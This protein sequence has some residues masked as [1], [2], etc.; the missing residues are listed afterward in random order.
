MSLAWDGM[1]ALNPPPLNAVHAKEQSKLPGLPVAI[2]TSFHPPIGAVDAAGA[3]RRRAPPLCA[4]SVRQRK[5]ESR[6]ACGVSVRQSFLIRMER[7]EV[8]L[9]DLKSLPLNVNFDTASAVCQ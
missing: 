5:K 3:L 1:S 6:F 7:P 2:V 4:R 9:S 8:A